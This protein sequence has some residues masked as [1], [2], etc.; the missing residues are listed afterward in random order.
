VQTI[1]LKCLQKEPGRR[2]GSAGELAEDLR[3]FLAHESIRAR[4]PSLGYQGVQFVRRHKGQALAAGLLLV[5][6][7]GGLSAVLLVQDRARRDLEAKNRQ[8]ETR[9]EM[10]RK[11]IA[12]FHTTVEHEKALDA[13]SFRP[14]RARLLEL[15]AEFYRELEGLLANETDTKSRRALADGYYQL[16]VLTERIGDQKAALADY[17]QALAIRRALLGQ[18]EAGPGARLDVA[19]A[20]RA[21]GRMLFATG[22]NAEALRAF[23]EARDLAADAD[24]EAPTNAVRQTLA[25][26]HVGIGQVLRHTGKPVE[27]LAAY[28]KAGVMYQGLDD[29]NPAVADY[30]LDLGDNHYRVGILL[31]EA[32]KPV[33]ALV[34]YEKARV[35]WEK[36]ARAH[37]TVTSYQ[38]TL[39]LNHVNIGFTQNQMGKPVEALAAYREAV[40]IQQEL[41]DAN[42]AVTQFQ[43]DL[44]NSLYNVGEL[45]SRTGKP[46]DAVTALEKARDVYRRL[47]D[48]NPAV[49]QFQSIL[50]RSHHSLGFILSETG[51]PGEA[52]AA[53]RRALDAQQKLADANP[54]VTDFQVNVA[55][56]HF[57][58]GNLLRD[59]G[60]PGE[61]LTAHEKARDIRQ[62][63]ADAHPTVAK[64]PRD[65]AWSHYSV[66]LMLKETG[67]P[68]EALAALEKARHIRQELADAHPT[69]A[70]F[71]LELS[72][73]YNS[74]GRLRVRQGR[75][76]EA[77]AALDAALATLGKWA[78]YNYEIGLSHAYRGWARARAGQSRDAAA[79]L[80]WAVELWSTAKALPIEMRFERARALVLL[81]G[82]AAAPHSGVTAAEAGAFADQAVASLQ[83]AVKGGWNQISELKE[84]DFDALRWREDFQKLHNELEASAAAKRAAIEE[85]REA[86][87]K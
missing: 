51:K 59:M 56:S 19:T 52:L 28:E 82:L 32:G 6:L 49:T 81:A 54:A 21:V 47:A 60:K 2:Y 78:D 5:A 74:I 23:E 70:E 39:A 84:A 18:P 12:A 63:L 77:F 68:G 76:A 25:H 14:L 69:V 33:E 4:R 3:R 53:Y 31:G 48:A 13:E 16:G 15:A 20:V 44:G 8:L 35:I 85:L 9:F 7:V 50:A 41:A 57:D 34:E 10:A 83:E 30:Q 22:D 65:L 36:L 66:G 87:K 58:I 24:A 86:Q 67:R 71:H 64:F 45:L 11:A 80:R 79:D 42:P 73:S 55:W 37:P 38:R 61:A 62:T 1:T 27:A 40:V 75:F 46:D 72:E 26:S 29:A 43:N 17:R